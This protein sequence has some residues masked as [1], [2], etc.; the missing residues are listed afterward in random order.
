MGQ[1]RPWTDHDRKPTARAR[2][3]HRPRRRRHQGR[4][5]PAPWEH[6]VPLDRP[7][8]VDERPHFRDHTLAVGQLDAQQFA[9]P[10]FDRVRHGPAMLVTHGGAVPPCRG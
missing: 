8:Q 1:F 5:Q 3:R 4:P 9:V 10:P 6:D 2:L 7:A